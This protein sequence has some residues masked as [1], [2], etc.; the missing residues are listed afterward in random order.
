[1]TNKLRTGAEVA[2]D[3]MQQQGVDY[4][5]GLPDDAAFAK[6][7]RNVDFTHMNIIASGEKDTLDQILKQLNKLV[8]IS[9]TT[10]TIQ[11]WPIT[12]NRWNRKNVRIPW[13]YRS[14]QDGQGFDG[15]WGRAHS[16]CR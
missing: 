4:I 10:I 8:D 16:I 7:G 14:N 5:F 12:K 3:I 11:G 15:Y 2:V 6:S 1:M 9:D 13:Y